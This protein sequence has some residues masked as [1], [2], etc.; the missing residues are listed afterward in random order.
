MRDRR[1]FTLIELLVV[2]TILTLLASIAVPRY[3]L[4]K[5]K[6]WVAAMVTDLRHLMTQQEAFYA[7]FGAY[8][9]SMVP[10]PDEGGVGGA[11]RLGF[12]P[13]EGVAVV[14]TYHNTGGAEGWSAVATHTR[15]QSEQ[16]DECGIFMGSPTYSPDPA[17]LTAGNVVCY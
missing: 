3:M 11:G 6:A 13:T 1:G 4:L 2:V 9:G 16:V 15:V 17:V 8:A 7:T 12:V 5:E 10:G 14:L